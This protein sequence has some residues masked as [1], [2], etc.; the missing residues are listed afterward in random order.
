MNGPEWL[1]DSSDAIAILRVSSHRQR[2]GVSH[3]A[4][5]KEIRDYCTFNGLN[6]VRVVKLIESAFD[7]DERKKFDAAMTGAFKAH[8]RHV[9]FYMYDRES[10]NLTHAERNEKLVKAGIFVIHYVRDRKVLHQGSSDSDFFIR[11]ISAATNKHYSRSLST[12]INDSMVQKA[13]NGWYPSNRPPLGYTT[14]RENDENGRELR[15]GLAYVI[16]DPDTRKV[17]WVQMEFELRARGL[18]YETIRK[19]VIASGLLTQKEIKQYKIGTIEYRI[20]NPFYEGYFLWKGKRYKGKH[21]LII[22]PKT[23]QLA[24]DNAGKGKVARTQDEFG[25]FAGGW[26]KCAECECLITYDPKTKVYKNGKTTTYHYYRCSNGKGFHARKTFITE[27]DIWEQFGQVIDLISISR[28]TAERLAEGLN[29]THRKVAA[30]HLK[31]IDE[32]KEELASLTEREDRAYDDMLSGLLD[33]EGFKRQRERIRNERVRLS[34][35]LER[36]KSAV[37]GKNLVSVSA[38]IELAMSAKSIYLS[39]TPRERREFL[40]LILSNP[41]LRG[42]TVEYTLKKHWDELIKMRGVNEMVVPPGSFSDLFPA[43]PD[44]ND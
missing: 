3:E 8:I 4:Q 16:P 37:S 29:V 1:G 15:R 43:F 44:E 7:S 31:K 33:A 13:E 11:D 25:L 42:L 20:K 39:R 10:R 6:L 41:S 24:R 9:L 34:D 2:D 18:S 14:K 17:K 27:Q 22:P 32:L 36:S 38:I 26:L 12:K 21:E 23:I 5:E 40:E 30:A 19:T 35:E 28:E